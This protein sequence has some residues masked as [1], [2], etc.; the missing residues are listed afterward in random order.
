M[1]EYRIKRPRHLGEIERLGCRRRYRRV[2][3]VTDGELTA[4]T[5]CPSDPSVDVSPASRRKPDGRKHVGDERALARRVCV[6]VHRISFP[7]SGT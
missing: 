2:V 6:E 7:R 5:A 4:D 1:S 3:K